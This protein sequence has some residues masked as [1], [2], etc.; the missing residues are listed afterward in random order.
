MCRNNF[1]SCA[2][3]FDFGDIPPCEWLLKN[4]T[5]VFIYRF[6]G[7]FINVTVFSELAAHIKSKMIIFTSGLL[8][9]LT[10]L[11]KFCIRLC[12]CLENGWATLKVQPPRVEPSDIKDF[13]YPVDK[14][15]NTS[16]PASS[17]VVPASFNVT[18][19]IKLV[20]R[21]RL[22]RLAINGKSKMAEPGEESNFS[23]K[24]TAV[25]F[26]FYHLQ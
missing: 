24:N 10:F 11:G 20:G 18:S 21:T 19:P 22:G 16:L 5:N 17:P 3:S 4:P 12:F 6:E 23:R 8:Q 25:T 9:G 2:D 26:R 13:Q 7:V 15:T 1:C 14:F